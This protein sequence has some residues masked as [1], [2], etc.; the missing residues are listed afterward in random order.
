[1]KQSPVKPE[2]KR[3]SVTNVV[4]EDENLFGDEEERAEEII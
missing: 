1:M 3:K 4:E 2:E